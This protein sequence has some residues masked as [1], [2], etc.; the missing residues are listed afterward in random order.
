MRPLALSDAL[1]SLGLSG[2]WLEVN[3]FVCGL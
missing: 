2:F 3:E 1:S